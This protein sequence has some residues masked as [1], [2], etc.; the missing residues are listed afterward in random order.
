MSFFNRRNALLL[1]A[2][3]AV[4]VAW[5]LKLWAQPSEGKAATP[6]AKAGTRFSFE[7]IESFDAKYEGDTPGHTGRAGGLENRRPNVALGDP[8][9]RADQKLG[10]I[11]SIV[12]SRVQ[13][14]LTI[15]FDPE[16]NA[17][18]AVGDVMWVD[19]NPASTVKGEE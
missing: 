11:T 16:P 17:R 1:L 19:L 8:V 6:V 2:L 7:V 5:Q 14:G 3:I 13:G 10:T 18:I 9:F 12:W 15:E 4:L